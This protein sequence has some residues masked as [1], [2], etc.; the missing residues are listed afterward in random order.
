MRRDPGNARVDRIPHWVILHHLLVS[1]CSPLIGWKIGLRQGSIFLFF[2]RFGC[3]P[4]MIFNSS[5]L[6]PLP[7]Y[8]VASFHLSSSPLLSVLSSSRDPP[9]TRLA[10]L[11]RGMVPTFSNSSLCYSV[12]LF[13]TCPLPVWIIQSRVATS[14]CFVTV[15]HC[16]VQNSLDDLENQRADY[17]PTL[18]LLLAG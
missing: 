8:L 17:L 15:P 12:P 14:L 11:H 18:L 3:H 2:S 4:E 9:Q 7:P 6:T 16:L 1:S 10:I 5:T 13:S